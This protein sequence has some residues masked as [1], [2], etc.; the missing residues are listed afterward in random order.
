MIAATK[1]EE[2]RVC[3]KLAVDTSE[4]QVLLS[5]G[6]HTA[7]KIGIEAKARIQIG[8]RVLWNVEKLKSY[9]NVNSAGC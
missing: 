5:C 4:L 1:K 3:D 6:R 7:E 2:T 8:K 9:L